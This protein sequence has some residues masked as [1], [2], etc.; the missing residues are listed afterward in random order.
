MATNSPEEEFPN[1]NDLPE[2]F[3]FQHLLNLP[4]DHHPDYSKSV[5]A[6]WAQP[7]SADVDK[8]LTREK[9]RKL[10]EDIERGRT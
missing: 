8:E 3:G 2:D 10:I 1:V 6:L 4:P 7:V 9:L 5:W